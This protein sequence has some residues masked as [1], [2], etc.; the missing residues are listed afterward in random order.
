M[1]IIIAVEGVMLLYAGLNYFGQLFHINDLTGRLVLEQDVEFTMYL[2]Q[3]LS[4][5]KQKSI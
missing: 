2:K 4:E 3:R 1:Q 5:K